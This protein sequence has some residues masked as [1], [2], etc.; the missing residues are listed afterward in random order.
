MKSIV[1]AAAVKKMN[2]S[3]NIT[4]FVEGVLPETENIYDDKFF[5]ALTGVVNALDN[6]K[7]RKFS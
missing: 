2:P 4:A 3:I 5:E 1:A 7:A 6:I